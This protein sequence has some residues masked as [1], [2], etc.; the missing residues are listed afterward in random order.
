MTAE[1]SIGVSSERDLT[2]KIFGG[3]GLETV[4]WIWNYF[5]HMRV[6][7]IILDPDS[8][9]ACFPESCQILLDFNIWTADHVNVVKTRATKHN[10]GPDQDSSPDPDPN[11]Q[12]ISDPVGSG[13]KSIG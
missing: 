12:I 4:L 3:G 1:Y 11:M 9:P 2:K 13:S 5:F 7:G 6:L 10:F 8:N